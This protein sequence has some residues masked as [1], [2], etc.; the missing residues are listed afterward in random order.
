MKDIHELFESVV[1]S[2]N[3]RELLNYEDLRDIIAQ[4]QN[5]KL[6]EQFV[7]IYQDKE[8]INFIHLRDL[9]TYINNDR[10]ETSEK[11]N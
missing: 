10:I 9:E 11:N 2:Y 6:V 7:K 4:V 3:N 1:T 8:Q 5:K